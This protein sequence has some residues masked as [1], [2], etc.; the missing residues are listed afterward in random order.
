MQFALVQKLSDEVA[1]ILKQFG[2]SMKPITRN[3]DFTD[4]D[5]AADVPPAVDPETGEVIQPLTE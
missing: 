3:I 4:T 2:E 1:G 5:E